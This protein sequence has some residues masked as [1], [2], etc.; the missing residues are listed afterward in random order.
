MK[1]EMCNI[2][3]CIVSVPGRQIQTLQVG[4][5]PDVPALLKCE[6]FVFYITVN[7]FVF[8]SWIK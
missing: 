4:G 6:N 8:W 7:K 2:V 5:R 3:D 1:D